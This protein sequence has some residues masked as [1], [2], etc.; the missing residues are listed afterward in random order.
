MCICTL[1]L[2]NA[3]L[4][5]ERPGPDRDTV[6]GE[7]FRAVDRVQTGSW[8]SESFQKAKKKAG[9]IREQKKGASKQVL[10]SYEMVH[11]KLPQ[12]K[13]LCHPA[14]RLLQHCGKVGWLRSDDTWASPHSSFLLPTQMLQLNQSCSPAFPTGRPPPKAR[15]R[16]HTGNVYPCLSRNSAIDGMGHSEGTS[17]HPAPQALVTVLTVSVMVEE[18]DAGCLCCQHAAQDCL[19]TQEKN[20]QVLFLPP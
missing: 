2:C 19:G 16:E 5:G 10:A 4:C 9:D 15:N 3:S 18:S 6:W 7:T 12:Q 1:S 11:S 13:Q 8:L 20:T 17:S 14:E